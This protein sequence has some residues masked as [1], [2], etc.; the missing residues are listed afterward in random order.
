MFINLIGWLC[1]SFCANTN[2]TPSSVEK[3]KFNFF[4]N[5]LDLN[6]TRNT[7]LDE[8]ISVLPDIVDGP[9]LDY[10]LLSKINE[11]FYK[12]NVLSILTNP[13]INELEKINTIN[14]YLLYVQTDPPV[15]IYA[16]GLIDDWEFDIEV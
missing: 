10:E 14:R 2:I 16:G 12:Q 8:R 6:E 13:N 3:T 4:K 1:F 7:G 11:N 9:N 5:K 15:N